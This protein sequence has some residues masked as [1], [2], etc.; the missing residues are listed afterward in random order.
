MT[1]WIAPA[2][3]AELWGVSL[4]QVMES[5]RSGGLE[6]KT[7]CGFTLVLVDVGGAAPVPEVVP[8]GPPPVTYRMLSIEAPVEVDV[9][10]ADTGSLALPTPTESVVSEAEAAALAGGPAGPTPALDFD[11]RRARADASKL[12]RRKLAA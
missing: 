6:C 12:R 7:D 1:C 11:W 10:P 5:V 8:V 2:L 3:A 4:N 9:E